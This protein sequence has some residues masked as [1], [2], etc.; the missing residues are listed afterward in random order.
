MTVLR[1]L[2]RGGIGGFV[3][4]FL[5]M[6]LSPVFDGNEPVS[7]KAVW[8]ALREI[9]W[10]GIFIIT[11]SGA[12]IWAWSAFWYDT[13]IGSLLRFWNRLSD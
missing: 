4:G 9:S 1:A 12:G 13:E 8:T 6:W 5:L 10:F 7:F 3:V 2:I 11:A